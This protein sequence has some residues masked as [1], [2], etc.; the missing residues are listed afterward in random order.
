MSIDTA[1]PPSSPPTATNPHRRDSF[2]YS[3]TDPAPDPIGRKIQIFHDWI[4]WTRETNP[5]ASTEEFS[6]AIACMQLLQTLVIWKQ[7]AADAEGSGT[8]VDADAEE[9]TLRLVWRIQGQALTAVKMASSELERRWWRELI[10][11]WQ[12]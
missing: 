1:T 10:E 7:E 5:A 6:C 4:M 9:R 12:L 3:P 8:G 11:D 2:S